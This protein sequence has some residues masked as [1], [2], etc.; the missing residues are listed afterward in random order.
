MKDIFE[1]DNGFVTII[2]RIKMADEKFESDTTAENLRDFFEEKIY[3]YAY[4][5]GMCRGLV[6]EHGSESDKERYK[7]MVKSLANE[8]PEGL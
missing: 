4:I 3:G 1:L 5:T 6:E 8:Y 7:I 2:E